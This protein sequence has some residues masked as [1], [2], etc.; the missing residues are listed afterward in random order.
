MIRAGT[1]PAQEERPAKRIRIG[2]KPRKPIKIKPNDFI[3]RPKYCK[4]GQKTLMREVEDELSEKIDLDNRPPCRQNPYAFDL[5]DSLSSFINNQNSFTCVKENN[6]GLKAHCRVY[7]NKK[8]SPKTPN[9]DNSSSKRYSSN[10]KPKFTVT[11]PFQTS[12]KPDFISLFA[13]NEDF[14]F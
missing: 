7:K 8:A 6:Q 14:N 12:L 4:T 3:K 13:K 2:R 9:F 11:L 5:E 10:K 1:A